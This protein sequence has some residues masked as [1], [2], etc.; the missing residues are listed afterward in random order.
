[1]KLFIAV[2]ACMPK[3][4]QPGQ[5]FSKPTSLGGLGF[6]YKWNMGWMNDTL[7]LYELEP[8]HRH[9]HDKNGPGLHI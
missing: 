6:T 3:S 7:T 1:M 4:P 2:V 9:H 5:A 8:I